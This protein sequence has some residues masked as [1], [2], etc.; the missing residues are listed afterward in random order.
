MSR[1]P[2]VSKA[3]EV[4]PGY[5]TVTPRIVVSDP[6]NLVQFLHRVFGATGEVQPGRPAEV[7]IGDSLLMISSVGERGAFPAFLYIYV[8]D[9]DET[10]SRALAAGATSIEAPVDQH[11]GDRRAMVADAFGNHYQIAH[12]GRTA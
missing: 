10:Y 9:V 7:R 3:S 2:Q 6:A 8:D 4:H 12:R 5:H 11:Y 1:T